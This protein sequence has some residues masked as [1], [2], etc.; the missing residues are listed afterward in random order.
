MD[1]APSMNNVKIIIF[2]SA[3]T[4]KFIAICLD[5]YSVCH[6]NNIQE[7]EQRMY[8]ILSTKEQNPPY[9]INNQPQAPKQFWELF[10]R[11]IHSPFSLQFPYARTF[12]FID[13]EITIEGHSK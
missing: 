1:L 10:R 8:G 7:L 6:G 3:Y 13:E 5:P 4:R 2:R 11:G 12:S 9:L